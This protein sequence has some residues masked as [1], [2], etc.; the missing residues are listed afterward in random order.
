MLL[1]IVGRCPDCSSKVVFMSNIGCQQNGG[2]EVGCESNM[3][4]W[5]FE[6]IFDDDILHSQSHS[7]GLPLATAILTTGL[8]WTD[9]EWLFQVA[10]IS[11][12]I[13]SHSYYSYTHNIDIA[14]TSLANSCVDENIKKFKNQSITVGVDGRWGS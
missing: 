9:A 10:N 1:D 11:L 4:D 8:T 7:I 14:V 12:P 6:W 2:F 13:S 3:C 5:T